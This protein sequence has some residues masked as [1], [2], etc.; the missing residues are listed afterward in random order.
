M[1]RQTGAIVVGGYA[2]GVGVVHS[3]A[4]QGIP[5]DVVLTMPQDIAQ[6]SR[7]VRQHYWHRELEVR[8]ES[9]IE[10]RRG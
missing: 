7:F 10:L 6:Y 5:V 3:L 1:E 8:P 4:R 9:L 2:N